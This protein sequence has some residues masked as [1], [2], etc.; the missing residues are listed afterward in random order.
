MS[1]LKTLLRGTIDVAKVAVVQHAR[2]QVVTAPRKGS[3][4]KDSGCT[5]CAAK[6]T[7]AAMWNRSDKLTGLDKKWQ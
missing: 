7:A 4:K 1:I 5:P 2:S 6:K 3:R